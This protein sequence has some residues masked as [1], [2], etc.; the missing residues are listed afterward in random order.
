MPRRAEPDPILP[1]LAT[2]A[3]A[4]AAGLTGDQ[5]RQRVRASSWL[6]VARGAYLPSVPGGLDEIDV[7]ARDRIDHVHRAVAAALRNPGATVAYDSAALVHGLPILGTASGEVTLAVPPGRW[8]G[9]RSGVRFRRLSLTPDEVTALRV[10]VTTVGRTWLD[11][12]CRGSLADSLTLGDAALRR[13]L[14]TRSDLADLV[15]RVGDLPGLSRA[16]RAL[17]YLNGLR[18]T[19]LESASFAYFVES[20]LP[21]PR[22]QVVIS[23]GGRF[24]ARVDFLWELP[25]GRRVV[26]ESDGVVKYGDKGEAYREKVREDELRSLGLVVI[27][28]GMGDLRGPALAQRLRRALALG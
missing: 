1:I 27:R 10:P 9:R 7:F 28:W 25:D 24:V 4:Q 21:L 12:S 23:H 17:P 3:D 5:V 11:V 8:T 15:T 16:V 13:I 20:G 26:G 2:R 6:R 18:E 19:P 14:V 22:M